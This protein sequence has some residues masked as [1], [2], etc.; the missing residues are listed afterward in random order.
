[1]LMLAEVD[2]GTLI[3]PQN[4]VT[5]AVIGGCTIAILA[6]SLGTWATVK[7]HEQDVQLKRDLVEK[8]F[9]ADEIDQIVKS[10]SKN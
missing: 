8:G 9:S 7:K 10:K 6:I 4:M 1:M 3:Q 5:F 2:W